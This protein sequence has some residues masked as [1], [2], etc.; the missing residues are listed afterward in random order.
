MNTL[1]QQNERVTQKVSQ[2]RT[3][4]LQYSR[5]HVSGPGPALGAAFIPVS[6]AELF[7]RSKSG[8]AAAAELIR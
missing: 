7:T 6:D 2:H 3:R 5:D 1:R 4:S 8:S